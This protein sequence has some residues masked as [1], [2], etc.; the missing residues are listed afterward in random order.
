[1][2]RMFYKTMDDF[3]GVDY[4]F[5]KRIIKDGRQEKVVVDI[6]ETYQKGL[7]N[8]YFDAMNFFAE[9]SLKQNEEEFIKLQ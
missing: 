9:N 6:Y 2:N 1:M 8:H 3:S 5:L 4:D 7:A